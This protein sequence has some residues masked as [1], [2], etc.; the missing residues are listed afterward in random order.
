M[1][2]VLIQTFFIVLELFL[3]DPVRQPLLP[4]SPRKKIKVNK[5][6]NKKSKTKRHMKYNDM[7]RWESEFVTFF[8]FL[9][10]IVLLW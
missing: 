5:N 6:K 1:Q 8:V 3:T 7:T 2:P 4:K 10:T 9:H